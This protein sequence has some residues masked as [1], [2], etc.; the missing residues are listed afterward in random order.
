MCIR[1]REKGSHLVSVGGI[2][3][4]PYGIYPGTKTS[5]DDVADGDSVAV[6]NDTTNEARALL[7]LQD[8]SLIHISL[9]GLPVRKEMNR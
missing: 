4:E 6:P 3:Y 7:L 1:D 8:L 5:L 9:T 2:H